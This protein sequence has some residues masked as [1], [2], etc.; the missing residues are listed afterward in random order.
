MR[1][2]DRTLLLSGFSAAKIVKGSGDRIVTMP[3]EPVNQA[4]PSAQTGLE[5]PPVWMVQSTCEK[6]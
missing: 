2:D 5:L 4:T 6:Q 1:S 3:H